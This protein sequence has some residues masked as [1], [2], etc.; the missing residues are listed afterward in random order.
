MLWCWNWRLSVP[1]SW[2]LREFWVA[3]VAEFDEKNWMVESCAEALNR[4]G[5]WTEVPA[6]VPVLRM[7]GEAG[8]FLVVVS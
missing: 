7:K 3:P 6:E 2:R 1:V 5:S 8:S 4:Q